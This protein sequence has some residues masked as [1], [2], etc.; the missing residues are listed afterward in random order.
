MADDDGEN[1]SFHLRR[2]STAGRKDEQTQSTTTIDV[3][4]LFAEFILY[5]ILVGNI[6][7]ARQVR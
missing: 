1:D 6:S 3:S 4:A 7:S 2:E 5:D